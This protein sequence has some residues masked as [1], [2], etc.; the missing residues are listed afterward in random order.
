M[1]ESLS[2]EKLVWKLS[3]SL[4]YM[5]IRV[6]LQ[7]S[8][9]PTICVPQNTRN[10]SSAMQ[11]T[12]NHFHSS[13]PK[14]WRTEA[15]PWLYKMS[16]SCINYSWYSVTDHT[17]NPQQPCRAWYMDER[18]CCWA[19][20]PPPALAVGPSTAMEELRNEGYGNSVG[21]CSCSKEH[22]IANCASPQHRISSAATHTTCLDERRRTWGSSTPGR[23]QA[24]L[25]VADTKGEEIC[26][27]Q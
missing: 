27:H 9:C 14:E 26:S 6:A 10:S 1:K 13:P 4:S 23:L 11:Y 25:R 12:A 20:A 7:T 2:S 17:D 3:S 8:G 5:F 15:S 24:Q 16:K 21:E 18:C 22:D 19:G